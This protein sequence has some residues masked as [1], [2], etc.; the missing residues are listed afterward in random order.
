[1]LYIVIVFSVHYFNMVTCRL[2]VVTVSVNATDETGEI[3]EH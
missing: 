2:K 1:M 3:H